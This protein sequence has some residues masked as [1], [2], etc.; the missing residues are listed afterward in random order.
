[1]KPRKKS[2]K[3]ANCQIVINMEAPEE[4]RIGLLESGRLEAFDIETFSHTQTRGNLYKGR[5][6]KIEPSLHAAFVDIG[7][8][9]NA[10]LPLTDIH[11]EYYGYAEDKKRIH[12]FLKKN[13][14]ILVQ[15]V[16][17]ETHIKGSAVTTYI[18]IP[19]RYLVLM[20]GTAQVG[21][22]RKIEDEE[23][24]QR[25]KQ[26]LKACKLPEG[27]GLIARTVAE[28]VP[29]A[30]I[31][32]DLRYLARLWSNL[33]KKA[34]SV[35]APAL[36]YKD[37]DLVKRFLRDYLTSDVGEILV[38]RQEVYDNI[39]AF[40]RIIAPRQVATV[41]FYQGDV[42]IFSHFDLETQ[43]DQV[44]QPMVSLPS[45]G[46]I[47]IEPTEALVSID[48]NSGKNVREKNI[49]ETALKTNLEA[50]DEIARQLRLR[51]LGGI[52]IVDFID[53]RNRTNRQQVEKRMRKCLKKDRART[54]IARISRFGVLE[55]V[56]QKIRSPVQLGSYCPCPYCH[57]RGV[58]M[59]VEALALADLR[60]ISAHLAG[61]REENSGQ[62]VLE[63]SS[64]VVSYLLNHKRLE[65]YNLEKNF[66][67]EISVEVNPDL[68]LE[69]HKLYSRTAKTS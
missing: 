16:K 48:V 26:I 65:L 42:P 7:L 1:M 61:G 23:E 56:R 18:S 37:R 12:E 60:R 69:E 45:G 2:S 24:R 62:L 36:I 64:Q 22:S 10:Y 29:K 68:G 8:P 28:G 33:R 49:E 40:L 67:V 11:P 19:A 15:I 30:G 52:I 9:R 4:C 55:L 27:V 21:V 57:G 54:E 17:E 6:V 34:Q 47:V 50:A 14:D 35:Q 31:Q 5:I 41:H 3:S 66:D 25:L 58:V 32:K 53:M 59:S 20:P 44:Y 39:K 38:D 13:Q 43:I 51:D 46:H 63:A